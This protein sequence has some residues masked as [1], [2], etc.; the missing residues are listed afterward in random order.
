MENNMPLL[1]HIVS[2]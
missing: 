1:C 2:I